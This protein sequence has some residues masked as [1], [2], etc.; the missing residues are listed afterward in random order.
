MLRR[1]KAM[2]VKFSDVKFSSISELFKQ[3]FPLG[4]MTT[5]SLAISAWFNFYK[6]GN[7]LK[8]GN[9]HSL[10]AASTANWTHGF[11]EALIGIDKGIWISNLWLIP[12]FIASLI[13]FR[14]ADS[15]WRQL[16]FLSWFLIISSSFIC[17]HLSYWSGDFTYA[18]RY[19]IHA[20]SLLAIVTGSAYAHLLANFFND[21]DSNYKN[22]NITMLLTTILMVALQ[23]PSIA[24]HC[25]LEI[26]QAIGTK[27]YARSPEITVTSQIGGQIPM[28]YKNLL[29]RLSTGKVIQLKDIKEEQRV[30]VENNSRWNFLP[31]L[32]YKYLSP[33]LAKCVGFFFYLYI[34]TS[35]ALWITATRLA[36]NKPQITKAIQL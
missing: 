26:Y 14:K 21:Q 5:V 27:G 8:T 33:T 9:E 18:S 2:R 35:L 15:Q 36:W 6:T 4:F 22:T 25:S 32:S 17:S 1:Q 16:F 13:L 28:R 30:L 7:I 31:Y 29:A 34:L 10:V 3:L 12:F 20:V 11:F 24:F 23:I 19:Q